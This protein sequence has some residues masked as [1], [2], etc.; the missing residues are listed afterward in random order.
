MTHKQNKVD[1]SSGSSFTEK[2]E[3]EAPQVWPWS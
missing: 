2:L 3:Q 1:A